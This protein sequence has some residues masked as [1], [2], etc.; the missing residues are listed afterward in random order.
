M[1]FNS[2]MPSR[3]RANSIIIIICI[4]LLTLARLH[5][6]ITP[7]LRY[8]L[9]W[10]YQFLQFERTNHLLIRQHAAALLTLISS[11]G[12]HVDAVQFTDKLQLCCSKWFHQATVQGADEF[13]QHML[14]ATCVNA[15]TR[16]SGDGFH[17][18]YAQYLGGFLRSPHYGRICGD[19]VQQSPLLRA[20]TRR[21]NGHEAL[22]HLHS[23]VVNERT[24]APDYVYG[25]Q[26]A[27]HLL[28]SIV[29]LLAA[30]HAG[31]HRR[32]LADLLQALWQPEAGL[33]GYFAQ[34]AGR[35]WNEQM[36]GNW[37][38]RNELA[39]LAGV[40]KQPALR[41]SRLSAATVLQLAYRVT[42]YLSEDQ[43]EEVIQLFEAVL[44]EP[45]HLNVDRI[46][47]DDRE[48]VPYIELYQTICFAHYEM[49][50]DT[51]LMVSN[52]QQPALPANWPCAPMLNML[53]DIMQPGSG[54]QPVEW[55]EADIIRIALQY[56][57]ALHAFG[58]SF[59]RPT[60]YLMTLMIAYLGENC[61]FLRPDMRELMGRSVQQFFAAHIDTHFDFETTVLDGGTTFE[62]LY[63][64]LIDHF[65]GTSYG[66]AAFGALVMVPLAQRYAVRWRQLVWSE[67]LAVMR[68]VQ[69]PEEDL[70]GGGLTGYL[71]PAEMDVTQL[72]YYYQALHTMRFVAG[73]VAQ[74][75]AEH[76][77]AVAARRRRRVG[78]ENKMIE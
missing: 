75:I 68:F 54:V 9:E 18:F 65:Q 63:L 76:H 77:L 2:H 64:L 61:S 20:I 22:P 72:K 74:R 12:A 21:P 7:A 10:C 4:G 8:M 36:R 56:M 51:G 28:T 57:D 17:A 78:D 66:D 58:V 40:L 53:R 6:E 14:L 29:N 13:S 55:T 37:F 5:S 39:L 30:L 31:Q 34:L 48:L 60:E 33:A 69:T 52:H 42:T 44:F 1:Q 15:C 25:Q 70:L 24:R 47:F 23:V 62:N 3:T 73:S 43:V 71:E 19:L 49:A 67:H 50:D 26:Y 11:M 32:L 45:G 27:V 41:E 35:P 46:R 38:V 16:I 59:M